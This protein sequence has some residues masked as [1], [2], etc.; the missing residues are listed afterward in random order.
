M[1]IEIFR[2]S[3]FLEFRAFLVSQDISVLNSASLRNIFTVDKALVLLR[4]WLII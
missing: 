4:V 1:D 2:K 3:G